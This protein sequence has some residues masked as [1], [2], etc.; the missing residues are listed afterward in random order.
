VRVMFHEPYFPFVSWPLHQNL[1]AVANRAMAAL[2]MSTAR[3]AY[4]STTAW[5]R[6]LRRYAPASLPFIWLPISSAIPVLDDTEQVVAMR[7]RLAPVPESRVVG[8]FGTYGALNRAL[9]IPAALLLLRRRPDARMCLLGS[10]S[11]TLAAELELRQPECRGR[12]IGLGHQQSAELAASLQACDVALQ[13]Y[14]DGASGRRTTL[15][16]ALANG[17]P[18]VTNAGDA[19]EDVWRSEGG[20][21]LVDSGSPALLVEAIGAL[22]DDDTR[23]AHV[24]SRGQLLYARCFAIEH[25]IEVLLAPEGEPG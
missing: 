11:D 3:M 21:A 1:L 10:G 15:M 20:V 22:L 14:P 2:V 8:H 23:R 7:R 19:T 24:A 25:T 9:L 18:V 16:A 12:V 13:P 5:T 4:V 17:V 6:R